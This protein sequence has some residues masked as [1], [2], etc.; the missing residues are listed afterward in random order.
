MFNILNRQG[1]YRH[2]L[3]SKE[4]S[5]LHTLWFLAWQKGQWEPLWS[6]PDTNTQHHPSYSSHPR[7]AFPDLC[8]VIQTLFLNLLRSPYFWTIEQLRQAWTPAIQKSII[9]WLW[10]SAC[11]LCLLNYSQSDRQN[12]QNLHEALGSWEY[13]GYKKRAVLSL[14]GKYF[15]ENDYVCTLYIKARPDKWKQA[16][17]PA[18]DSLWLPNGWGL[19]RSWL[20]SINAA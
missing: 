8:Q 9:S 7:R 19:C 12:A 10:W 4:G 20:V 16:L 6:T 5:P 11:P 14:A 13:R 18:Y 3:R 17:S 1:W 15:L 2:H